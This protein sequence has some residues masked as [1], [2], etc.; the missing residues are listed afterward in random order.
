M[1]EARPFY[2]GVDADDSLLNGAWAHLTTFKML[3]GLHQ[4]SRPQPSLTRYYL[5]LPDYPQ[6]P[7]SSEIIQKAKDITRHSGR[8]VKPDA[9]VVIPR[10]YQRLKQRRDGSGLHL[11]TGRGGA[12]ER[13]H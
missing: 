9:K 10:I 13:G 6:H 4:F 1:L 8:E 3:L 7:Q 11:A 12:P 5:S 2:I